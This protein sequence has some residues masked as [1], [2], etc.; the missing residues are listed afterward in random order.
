[1]RHAAARGRHAL[2]HLVRG[3]RCPGG[4][5]WIQALL[6]LGAAVPGGYPSADPSEAIAAAF[7]GVRRHEHRLPRVVEVPND[8]ERPSP[9]V[10]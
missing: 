9:P 4:E 6:D 3:D 10:D 5:G 1:V 8:A 7:I 2:A